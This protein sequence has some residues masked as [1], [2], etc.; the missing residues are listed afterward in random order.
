MRDGE[1]GDN[2]VQIKTVAR[3]GAGE[4]NMTVIWR[5]RGFLS[6]AASETVP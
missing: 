1:D 6:L 5:R 2:G 3:T 4:E